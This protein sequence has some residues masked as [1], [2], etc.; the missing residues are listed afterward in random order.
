MIKIHH[1][2][3]VLTSLVVIVLAGN[4]LYA[5]VA[6]ARKA[7]A[8]I[9]IFGKLYGQIN[10]YADEFNKA[11][12]E[13]RVKQLENEFVLAILTQFPE[14]EFLTQDAVVSP[15]SSFQKDNPNLL[16]N[17]IQALK[18]IGFGKNAAEF[19][20]TM[21]SMINHTKNLA[22]YK[23]LSQKDHTTLTHYQ[24]QLKHLGITDRFTTSD[25]DVQARKDFLSH[26]YADKNKIGKVAYLTLINDLFKVA[27]LAQD[28]PG[29]EHD[30]AAVCAITELQ[31]TKYFPSLKTPQELQ[32]IQMLLQANEFATMAQINQGEAPALALKGLLNIIDRQDLV[33]ITVME[34]LLDISGAPASANG[35]VY[36]VIRPLEKSLYGLPQSLKATVKGL[37]INEPEAYQAVYN[38]F[39][40][41]KF[42][43]GLTAKDIV[44]AR[45]MAMIRLDQKKLEEATQQLN[46]FREARAS[47]SA[48]EARQLTELF[49]PRTN[50]MVMYGPDFMH[51]VQGAVGE[52][53][54]NKYP[55][56]VQ[57]Y[58]FAL[59]QMIQFA[60][61][62]RYLYNQ[63]ASISVVNIKDAVIPAKQILTHAIAAQEQGQD[64][65]KEVLNQYNCLITSFSGGSLSLDHFKALLAAKNLTGSAA[66][67][68][69]ISDQPKLLETLQ[70]TMYAYQDPA[71][72]NLLKATRPEQ[73]LFCGAGGG[74]DPLSAAAF[75]GKSSQA[76]GILIGSS[77][78]CPADIKEL[79]N[80]GRVASLYLDNQNGI[81]ILQGDGVIYP[82]DAVKDFHKTSKMETSLGIQPIPM[83]VMDRTLNVFDR[84]IGSPTDQL[85]SALA[86]YL[87]AYNI[88]LVTSVDTGCDIN[89]LGKLEA[90]NQHIDAIEGDIKHA[91]IMDAAIERAQAVYGHQVS[92]TIQGVAPGI[93]NQ[94]TKEQQEAFI[95]QYKLVLTKL[96]PKY[97]EDLYKRTAK[98]STSRTTK[99]IAI[100]GKFFGNMSAEQQK[101]LKKYLKIRHK[102]DKDLD[103]LSKTFRVNKNQTREYPDFVSIL[104]RLKLQGER[105]L[106]RTQDRRESSGQDL[107]LDWV[108]SYLTI[109]HKNLKAIIKN[110]YEPTYVKQVLEGYIHYIDQ[111]EE[112]AGQEEALK[113][114]YA[115]ARAYLASV[116]NGS[117]ALAEIV[118]SHPTKAGINMLQGQ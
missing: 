25:Q 19:E 63:D 18:L 78:H 65:Y 56:L 70:A 108:T 8:P 11:T 15:G 113:Q 35:P 102:K 58:Q 54:A 79:T 74:S 29:K 34:Q 68:S 12:T 55:Y 82:E 107:D 110:N 57:G 45:F 86:K 105:I 92:Y 99:Q 30:Q 17:R 67:I 87:T 32:E 26:V 85:V 72:I 61:A 114:A 13:A 90:Q 31:A 47:L 52:T 71:I 23:Y 91:V 42:P 48:N 84:S 28:F 49:D 64:N 69:T 96:S 20:R 93:D 33:D 94:T 109:D 76:A 24:T 60:Q 9:D 111:L 98:Q 46:A 115:T 95:K 53:T 80:Q 104:S 62:A 36:V 10:Q 4:S 37:Q 83:I 117:A 6:P 97:F 3:R 112:Q 51:N 27:S 21:T 1:F 73:K 39:M 100:L 22:L 38:I 116:K 5:K 106:Y 2:N 50:I 103:A 88:Q 118:A 101:G 16:Q 66:F 41:S 44:E 81:I 89:G 75:V 40:E 43:Q 59:K 7:Q 77:R 14:A